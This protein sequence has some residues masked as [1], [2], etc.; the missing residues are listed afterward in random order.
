MKTLHAFTQF[1]VLVSLPLFLGGC[2]EKKVVDEFHEAVQF[3]QK[4][5][6]LLLIKYK[7]YKY[8]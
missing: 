3:G 5:R 7:I 2:G 6:A 1:V 4:D 8:K